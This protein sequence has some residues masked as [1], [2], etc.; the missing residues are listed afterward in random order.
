M[1]IGPCTFEMVQVPAGTFQMGT[2]ATGIGWIE[3]NGLRPVHPVTITRP[4]LMQK[5][6]SPWPSSRPS[7][8]LLAT[9]RKRS[10]C[11]ARWSQGLA[12]WHVTG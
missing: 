6:Q 3:K 10:K 5:T 12:H 4:F 2:D 11:E 1:K 9:G 8:T 7:W